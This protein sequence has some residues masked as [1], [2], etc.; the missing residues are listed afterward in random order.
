LSNTIELPLTLY[1][2]N[3]DDL[4]A[5][6]Q[7]V[8]A[9]L[10]SDAPSTSVPFS[11]DQLAG[12]TLVND[13]NGNPAL[14]AR[15]EIPR[16]IYTQGTNTIGT[17]LL[18]LAVAG[19]VIIGLLGLLLERVVL[20]RIDYLSTSVAKIQRG[21]AERVYVSGKDELSRLGEGLN[22]MLARIES[23]Q[24]SI[25]ASEDRLRAVV[26]NAPI[27]M[28][29]VDKI[30]NLTFVQ[31]GQS[32]RKDV[33][34]NSFIGQPASQWSDLLALDVMGMR[35]ALTGVETTTVTQIG[36]QIFTTAYKTLRDDDDGEIV[37]VIGV[38]T[39]ITEMR[40]AEDQLA[41][42]SQQ[43]VR[44]HELI[45]STLDHLDDAMKRS[46]NIIELQQYIDFAQQ[47]FKKLG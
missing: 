47:E 38:A 44:T 42:K 34:L 21:T 25:K 22:A 31:G 3:A 1:L 27:M 46:A 9:T 26:N 28:W 4:P 19:L 18:A 8:Q 37:G 32:Q 10:T 29:A 35:R 45:R 30:E 14:I 17:F 12:Y 13:V 5:D 6:V 36:D 7:Q 16:A 43:L 41:Q 15:I 24:D 2:A 11:D 23:Y 20:R 33:Q 40:R 39:N